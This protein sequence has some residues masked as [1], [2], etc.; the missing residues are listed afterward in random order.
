MFYCYVNDLG[1]FAQMDVGLFQKNKICV[2]NFRV[3]FE[4]VFYG[5]EDEFGG[6]KN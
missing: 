3:S 6:L 1:G 5:Y 4:C 2:F